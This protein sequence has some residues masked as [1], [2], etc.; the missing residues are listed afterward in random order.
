MIVYIKHFCCAI[1][2]AL[3]YKS[4]RVKTIEKK[5]AQIKN[6]RLT[7]MYTILGTNKIN[8]LLCKIKLKLQYE[9]QTNQNQNTIC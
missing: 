6:R 5:L 1:L 2:R 4:L 3:L 7:L 8:N 9:I